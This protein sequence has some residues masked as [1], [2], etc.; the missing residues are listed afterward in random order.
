MIKNPFDEKIYLART[1]EKEEDIRGAYFRDQTAIIHSMPFRRLKHKTQVF[2]S[3][4]NDHVCTRI[5]HVMHVATIAKTI[6]KGLNSQG[7]DL[8]GELAFAI[9]LGHDLGHAPFGH[10]GE[11]ILNAKLGG[12][13]AF[14]HELNSYRVIEHLSNNGKGLNLTYAVKDGIICHNGEKFEQYLNPVID[15]PNDL[16][17]IKNRSIKPSS[18][19]GCIVRFSDKIAYLGRDIDD[20]IIANFIKRNDVPTDIKEVLGDNNSQIINTL[21]I[22]LIDN[23]LKENKLGFSDDKYDKLLKLRDFNYKNIY[24]NY[25]RLNFKTFAEKILNDLFDNF[26]NLFEKNKRDYPKYKEEKIKANQ[27]F[28]NY[29]SKMNDFYENENNPQIIVN[30]FVAG[31]T[32]SYALDCMKQITFPEPIF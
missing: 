25:T 14:M 26:L 5:E 28:G 20:A 1:R 30:D 10:D 31:M 16:E 11:S 17:A 6:C 3:P 27:H 19:E 15:K 22:D 18:L 2:F 23:T 8:D 4:E 7:W 24:H 21:V 12:N 9:G 32:D 29:I 13:M